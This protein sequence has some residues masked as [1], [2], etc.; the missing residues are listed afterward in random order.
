[1]GFF[2]L[3]SILYNLRKICKYLS[4]SLLIVLF[5]VIALLLMGKKVN[6]VTDVVYNA[7]IDYYENSDYTDII[8]FDGGGFILFNNTENNKF[9][10]D[11]WWLRCLNEDNIATGSYTT[12]SSGVVVNTQN[13]LRFGRGT[14]RYNISG[15]VPIVYSTVDIYM[16]NSFEDLYFTKNNFKSPSFLNY[17]DDQWGNTLVNGEFTYFFIDSYTDKPIIVYIYDETEMNVE[18]NNNDNGAYSWS[19][20]LPDSDENGNSLYCYDNTNN[21]YKYAIPVTVPFGSYKDGHSYKLVI[22][23]RNDLDIWE[24]KIYQW[25]TDFSQAGIAKQEENEN[26]VMLSGI[27]S[28]YQSQREMNVFFNNRNY[29]PSNITDNMPSSSQY[30]DPTESSFNNIFQSLYNAFTNNNTQTVRFVIPFT[31]D[32]YID[33]PSDLVTSRLPSVIIV[34]IQSFYWFIICRFI[35]KDISKIVEKAKSGEIL[36]S[37]S[38]GNI[39]TDLL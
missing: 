5:V 14:N 36:D 12:S 10:L 33:I 4:L 11:V 26:D 20:V 19:I 3:N 21:E 34:L 18:S 28:I 17:D 16:N 25:T 30:V 27:N 8:A 35:V 15:L 1:M 31:N 7:M 24:D 37:S 23:Y 2:N 9:Y 32:Q 13:N 22:Q 6:A 38:D 39:K 29:N